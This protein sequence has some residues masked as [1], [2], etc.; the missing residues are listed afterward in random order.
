MNTE[1]N[2]FIKGN[3][4]P[5]SITN[6]DLILGGKVNPAKK[7]DIDYKIISGF[8]WLFLF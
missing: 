3:P 5:N 2:Y 4:H 8:V 7:L 1:V 6:N